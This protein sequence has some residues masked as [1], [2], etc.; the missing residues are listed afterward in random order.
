M[1]KFLWLRTKWGDQCLSCASASIPSRHRNRCRPD[2]YHQH[3]SA[4]HAPPLEVQARPV[5]RPLAALV[6]NAASAGACSGGGQGSRWNRAAQDVDH[7]AYVL[8]ARPAPPPLTLPS[9]CVPRVA[10]TYEGRTS[11]AVAVLGQQP[12]SRFASAETCASRS[13]VVVSVTG[14]SGMEL[15]LGRAHLTLALTLATPVGVG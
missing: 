4:A 9:V 12:A 15:E 1:R 11:K 14:S 3:R 13:C 6:T 8:R 5:A 10:P 2:Q 7:P